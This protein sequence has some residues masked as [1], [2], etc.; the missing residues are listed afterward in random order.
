MAGDWLKVEKATTRKPEVLRI[1]GLL[2]ID[3][4][5]AFGLCFEFWSWCDDQ[6]TESYVAGVTDVTVDSLVGYK[7]FASALI[8]VGWLQVRNGSLVIPNFDR[9]LAEGAKTR[10]LTAKRMKKSRASERHKSDDIRDG[11]SVTNSSP[12][13]RREEINT[14][15]SSRE[16]PNPP[17]RSFL[18]GASEDFE[19]FWEAYPRKKGRADA[20]LN[21]ESSILVVQSQKGINESMAIGFL[22]AKAR[23]IAA[24]NL[25][26]KAPKFVP[27]AD[28]FLV[29]QRFFDDPK[30][31]E[32][33]DDPKP[34]SRS[35]SADPRGN[36]D[37][38][39]SVLEKMGFGDG[40]EQ[41]R[42]DDSAAVDDS[43]V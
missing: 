6:M 28:V 11:D 3:R 2:G 33:V 29:K 20:V 8:S 40:N 25:A 30:E 31:W 4:L 13:K 38:M 21:W 34:R 41:G 5:Q 23:E 16:S 18:T 24:S 17:D 32:Q 35:K 26:R 7:G 39:N 43:L 12:E 14:G 15:V 10:A 1:A 36:L 37:V 27:G 42:A 9:H 22:I 19:R